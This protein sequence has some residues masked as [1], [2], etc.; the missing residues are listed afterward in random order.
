MKQRLV[1]KRENA[2]FPDFRGC[3]NFRRFL[4]SFFSPF[5]FKHDI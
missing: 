5:W 2:H 3:S 4:D 1:E